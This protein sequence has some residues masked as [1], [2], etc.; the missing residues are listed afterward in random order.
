MLSVILQQEPVFYGNILTYL[1]L[2]FAK[3]LKPLLLWLKKPKLSLK[4]LILLDC[5][6]LVSVLIELVFTII[7]FAI[8]A[9]CMFTKLDIS[10]DNELYFDSADSLSSGVNLL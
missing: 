5:Y 1:I 10:V 3:K 4:L 2:K 6:L 9:N 7:T 8:A